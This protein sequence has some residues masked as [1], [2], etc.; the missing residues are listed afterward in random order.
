MLRCRSLR[1]RGAWPAL[2]ALAL[3]FAL[4]FGH[5]HLTRLSGLGPVS[6]QTTLVLPFSPGD[7]PVR[8]DSGPAI[9]DC[10]I[11][12]SIHLAGTLLPPTAGALFAAIQVPS[13][14]PLT[15]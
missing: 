3:Q 7:G 9:D 4:S 13:I 5:I 6:V 10:A 1:Q 2:F 8:Q 15:A 12:A 14:G 11:C